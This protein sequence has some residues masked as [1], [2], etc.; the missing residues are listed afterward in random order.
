MWNPGG[1]GVENKVDRQ[2]REWTRENWKIQQGERLGVDRS[3]VEVQNL[4]VC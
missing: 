2:S 4:E 1:T 3:V